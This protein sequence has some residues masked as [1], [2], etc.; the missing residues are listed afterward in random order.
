LRSRSV[1]S[2]ATIIK[3]LSQ[4]PGISLTQK[5]HKFHSL[6][7]E[8]KLVEFKTASHCSKDRRELW[9]DYFEENKWIFGYGLNYQ[10]LRQEQNQPNYGGTRLDGTGGQRGDY[11]TS[12]MGDIRFTVLVEIKTP[13]TPLLQ[14]TQE[15][16]KRCVEPFKESDGC[17]FRNFRP[18]YLPGTSTVRNFQRI[19]IDSKQKE[20]IPFSLKVY[21]LLAS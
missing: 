4:S 21:W 13:A 1:D 17:H 18:T 10:I 8:E 7:G 19:E 15:I 11:I 6:N 12:T 3:Q 14:G 16:R 2:V 5:R 20:F 9:Q